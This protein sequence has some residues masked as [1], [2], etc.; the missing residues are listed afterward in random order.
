LDV[1]AA[2]LSGD[3]TI[4]GVP[5]PATLEVEGCRRPSRIPGATPVVASARVRASAARNG[6]LPWNMALEAGGVVVGD[7][8]TI[9]IEA[10]LVARP[11]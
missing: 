9:E 1:L 3:L 2:L 8:V 5:R 11:A 7:E 4:R 6:G 10:E